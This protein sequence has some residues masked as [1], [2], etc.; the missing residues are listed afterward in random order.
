[1][2]YYESAVQLEPALTMAQQRLVT[3][4]CDKVLSNPHKYRRPGDL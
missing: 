2:R 3:L 1:M 4:Q